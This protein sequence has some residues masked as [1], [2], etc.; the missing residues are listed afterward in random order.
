MFDVSPWPSCLRR[1]LRFFA[2]VHASLEFELSHGAHRQAALVVDG[3]L[4]PGLRCLGRFNPLHECC[5]KWVA[6][7]WDCIWQLQIFNLLCA[8]Q[9]RSRQSWRTIHPGTH[10]PL[11]PSST[12][13]GQDASGFPDEPVIAGLRGWQVERPDEE[14]H[15]PWSTEPSRQRCQSGSSWSPSWNCSRSDPPVS[16]AV[17]GWWTEE[18]HHWSPVEELTLYQRCGSSMLGST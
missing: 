10:L 16:D 11:L 8:F 9:I 5:S 1:W 18:G 6:R 2:Q 13:N 14:I 4:G 3:V 7:L 12:V 17:Q 15:E